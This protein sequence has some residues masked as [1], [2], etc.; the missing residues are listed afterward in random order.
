MNEFVDAMS[1][2]EHEAPARFASSIK[3]NPLHRPP[4]ARPYG[5]SFKPV[6]VAA[7]VIRNWKRNA[8]EGNFQQ[9]LLSAAVTVPAACRVRDSC[10]RST[11]KR[12]YR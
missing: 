3:R 7:E 12:E 11:V 1:L 8:E 6:E 10:T 2:G 9:K 4:I 5:R